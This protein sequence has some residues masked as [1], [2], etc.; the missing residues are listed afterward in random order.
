MHLRTLKSMMQFALIAVFGG[1]MAYAQIIS[2]WHVAQ[3]FHAHMIA[4]GAL[5]VADHTS[6]DDHNEHSQSECAECM[7]SQVSQSAFYIKN[8]LDLP[9]AYP[10]SVL[11]ESIQFLSEASLIFYHGRAPPVQSLSF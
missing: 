10:E 7:L 9:T 6:Q 4:H 1:V 3:D 11:P 2:S 5:D 8:T